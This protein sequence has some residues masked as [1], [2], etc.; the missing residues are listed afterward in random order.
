VKDG[1]G[2]FEGVDLELVAADGKA[3]ATARSDY[4]GYFLFDHAAYGRYT[5]RI[6]ASSAAAI[7]SALAIG[8]VISV[9]GEKPSV[10][11]GALTPLILAQVASAAAPA[12]TH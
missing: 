5:L 1:G 9:S 7:H 6:A 2:G 10:R 8:G 12:S 11:L 4:D 3:V